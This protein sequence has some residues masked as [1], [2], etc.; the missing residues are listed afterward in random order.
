VLSHRLNDSFHSLS[1]LAPDC[2]VHSA[3]D[4]FLPSEGP[5][6]PNPVTMDSASGDYDLMVPRL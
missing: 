4:V 2:T 5:A 3:F 1:S 6:V